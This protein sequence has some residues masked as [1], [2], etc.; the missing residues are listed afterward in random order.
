M[1]TFKRSNRVA[2]LFGLFVLACMAGGCS[3]IGVIILASDTVPKDFPKELKMPC[4][5]RKNGPP[6]HR[7]ASDQPLV[8]TCD[9]FVTTKQFAL[10]VYPGRKDLSIQPKAPTEKLPFDVRC[11]NEIC[12]SLTPPGETGTYYYQI[13]DGGEVIV[14][15]TLIVPK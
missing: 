6:P 4:R 5:E 7:N 13:L 14:D 8:V 11:E 3:N 15:P 1:V 10:W 2:S 9:T 12:F